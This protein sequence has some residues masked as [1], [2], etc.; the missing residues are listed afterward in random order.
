MER[1]KQWY[2][3]SLRAEFTALLTV[4]ILGDRR[5]STISKV[6]IRPVWAG[7][8]APRDLEK[9]IKLP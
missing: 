7:E 8:K 6:L 5:G 2:L 4:T 3:T 9:S 1:T